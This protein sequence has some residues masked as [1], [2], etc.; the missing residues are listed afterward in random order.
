MRINKIYI[1]L[2]FLLFVVSLSAKSYKVTPYVII[3]DSTTVTYDTSEVAPLTL[4]RTRIEKYKNSP[5]FNYVE[6][7]PEDNWYTRLKAKLSELYNAFIRWL[8][9]GNEAVGFWGFIVTILPYL[10]IA[11]FI[12]FMIWLILRI[13][14]RNLML[15]S[16]KNAQVAFT[17]D[18][19]IIQNQDIGA[20]IQQALETKNYRLAVRLHYL[21][22]LQQLSGKDYIH[23]ETQKTNH[24]YIYE[25][26]NDHMR[27]LFRE[28]TGIYDYIWYGN[29]SVDEYAFAKAEKTF[30]KLSN[31]L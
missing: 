27:G 29:F 21:L 31:L 8:L 9:G 1:L 22:A 26:E 24:D 11:G 19:D 20:L 30:T 6:E 3:Q 2:F 15:A 18:E 12:G 10:F 4:D 7:L 5:D 13:D 23:W 16:T 25:L 14:N 17:D 28:L